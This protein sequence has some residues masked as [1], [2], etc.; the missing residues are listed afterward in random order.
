MSTRAPPGQMLHVAPQSTSSAVGNPNLPE[1]ELRYGN[2]GSIGHQQA[3]SQPLA[4][5]A[6]FPGG[7]GGHSRVWEE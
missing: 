4:G 6:V 5:N 3:V 7:V 1:L 2:G